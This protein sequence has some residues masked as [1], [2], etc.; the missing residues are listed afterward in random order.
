MTPPTPEPGYF[1]TLGHHSNNTITI[2][3]DLYGSQTITEPILVALLHSEPLIRLST[4]HQ[5]QPKR[6]VRHAA[7]GLRMIIMQW[8][9]F[10][11]ASPIPGVSMRRTRVSCISIEYSEVRGVADC[12]PAPS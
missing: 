3:D 6:H 9:V 11:L 7:F 12:P 8:S 5:T 1:Q 10:R 2:H 4:V